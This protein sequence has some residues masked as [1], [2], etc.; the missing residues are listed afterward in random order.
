MTSTAAAPDRIDWA[1]LRPALIGLAAGL[2]C[3]GLLFHAEAVAAVDVWSTSTAYSHCFLVL[4][5]ALWL[6]WDRRAAARGLAP[7]PTA[8]PTLAAVPLGLAWFV[9][10]RL[11]LMEGRQLAVMLMLQALLVALLGWRLARAFAPAVIYLIFLVPVGSFLVP[12]LQHFTAGFIDAGLDIAGIPHFVDSFTIEIPEGIFYVAEACAGLRFLIAAVAF[13]AL[14]GF[15]MY[16]GTGRRLG[17]LAASVIVPIVA[18]G[19]RALGIVIAGHLIGNAEAAAADHIIYGW[20]FFSAVIVL[21]AVAG[22]PFRETTPAPPP[23]PPAAPAA[24]ASA[25]QAVW[26]A[27]IVAL[28]AA[29]GPVAVSALARPAAAPTLALP[30]FAATPRCPTL[31]D[32]PGGP[33]HFSCGGVPLIARVRVLPAGAP[34]ADLRAARAE[35]TGERDAA[36]SVTST[37]AVPETDPAAWRLVELDDPV[38]L[39]A[40]ATWIDGRPNTGGLAGRLRLA[41]ESIAG[42]GTPPVLVAVTLQPPSLVGPDQRDAARQTLR[43]FL[44]AQRPLLAAIGAA[45]RR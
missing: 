40:T 23:V 29:A 43:Q 31:G 39:T 18:N 41:W 6:A 11:G 13:G 15:M 19:I 34:P 26:V 25:G 42:G 22:L 12:S 10:E 8:W 28:L 14:Y 35:A 30:G 21:L 38:R 9:A 37:L 4:P 36:D 27:G 32:P 44:A 20:V 45:T 2:A 5:V 33:Q 24:P 16:R 1:A 17:F 3:F 7:E